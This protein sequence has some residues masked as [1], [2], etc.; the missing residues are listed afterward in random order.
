[1]RL[2][3]V[4]Q[5]LKTRTAA[6]SGWKIV[7]KCRGQCTTYSTSGGLERDGEKR[8]DSGCN[9]I[10]S[11]VYSHPLTVASYQRWIKVEELLKCVEREVVVYWTSSAISRI[12]KSDSSYY[13]IVTSAVYS[14]SPAAGSC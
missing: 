5:S 6:M 4:H 1:M 8:N 10:I 7:G 3:P 13:Y 12:M 2:R 9:I 14:H 11:D